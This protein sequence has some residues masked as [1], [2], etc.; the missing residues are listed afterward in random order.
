MHFFFRVYNLF[1]RN[2]INIGGD[3]TTRD[4]ASH[5][6]SMYLEIHCVLMS[7]KASNN[8]LSPLQ[9]VVGVLFLVIGGLN[10]N[11][12]EYHR[13][14]VNLETNSWALILPFCL[15]NLQI[16]SIVATLALL[17]RCYKSI[18][19][20]FPG[21]LTNLTMQPPLSSSSSPS[22]MSS[23]MLLIYLPL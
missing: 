23:S 5:K 12:D 9:A 15:C 14:A 10:I 2:S 11:N 7:I 19:S 20:M 17:M 6:I 4:L 3:L 8:K 21:P 13:Q 16:Q 1:F 18:L 22:L